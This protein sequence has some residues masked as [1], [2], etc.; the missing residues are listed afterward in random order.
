MDTPSSSTVSA[1]GRQKRVLP[2][3]SRRGGPGV[4]NCD[5]DVLILET[6]KR[7]YEIEPLIPLSTPFLLSTK[8]DAAK[9][10]ESAN[11]AG[12]H[13]NVVANERYFARPEVL[14]AFREQQLIQTP[15]YESI[16]ESSY[17]GTR[18]RPRP[19]DATVDTSDAAYEKRHRKFETLEKRQRLR[20]K[21][22]L[23][24]EHYKLKE[25]IEQLRA[26]DSAAFMTLPASS[27]S[28]A[29]PQATAELDDLITS[30]SPYAQINGVVSNSE[31][32]RRR[33]EMLETAYKLEKRYAYLLPPDRVRKTAD[34]PNESGAKLP[35]DIRDGEESDTEKIPSNASSRREESMKLRIPARSSAS[36][37]PAPS[38]KPVAPKKPRASAVVP[39][40]PNSRLVRGSVTTPAPQEQET[41]PPAQY[42][43]VEMNEPD[44][45]RPLTPAPPSS[46]DYDHLPN[47]PLSNVRGASNTAEPEVHDHMQNGNEQDHRSVPPQV[48]SPILPSAKPF[49]PSGGQ[50]VDMADDGESEK[51]PSEDEATEETEHV[52]EQQ[53]PPEPEHAPEPQDEQEPPAEPEPELQPEPRSE[54][55]A[56]FQPEPQVE[57]RPEPEPEPIL[58]APKKKRGR[59]KKVVLEQL[60][61][62][63]QIESQ[64][65]R[66]LSTMLQ[67]ATVA[68]PSQVPAD[69]SKQ[70]ETF[71]QPVPEMESIST[72]SKRPY[73][74]KKLSAVAVEP[75][76][77]TPSAQPAET[78]STAG[79][80]KYLGARGKPYTT[81]TNSAGEKETTFCLLLMA[82][83][84]KGTR[85]TDSVRHTTSFGIETPKFTQ[86]DFEI[87]EWIHFPESEP[88]TP[89]VAQPDPHREPTE[90][91]LNNSALPIDNAT[92]ADGNHEGMPMDVD[93]AEPVAPKPTEQE[94]NEPFQERGDKQVDVPDEHSM[95]EANTL[96]RSD[97][98]VQADAPTV[99][100]ELE[101]KDVLPDDENDTTTP[102]PEDME[103]ETDSRIRP[104]ILSRPV[105][106]DEDELLEW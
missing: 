96:E 17:V 33:K 50:D 2:S 38:P 53:V 95:E 14:K 89:R 34:T 43:D 12:I 11:E 41:P 88:G 66:D 60:P 29:P 26:M 4:G 44:N 1:P 45:V 102:A 30:G 5:S 76:A 81:Y 19:E 70:Q 90:F 52:L 87:P 51:A 18:T 36:T 61:A 106:D 23:K 86:I 21:E 31:G 54:L 49:I 104:R 85:T 39:K 65:V 32:E 27:F 47:T 92:Q 100:P 28:P 101:H 8:A 63:Q 91:S 3:R 77:R 98:A 97:D 58:P 57:P 40:Q 71:P 82:A 16:G 10:T 79:P 64:E 13:I 69:A 83:I 46:F 24:H 67:N 93:T 68:E 62:Q 37:T 9:N 15:E 74:R 84:R 75:S 48:V 22:K 99:A 103:S 42:N 73:K 6:Y 94:Y 55:E 78:A 20:E 25:R 105:D 56:E 7:Q 59:K 80:R 72:T 35:S